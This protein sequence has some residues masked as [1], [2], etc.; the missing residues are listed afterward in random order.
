MSFRTRQDLN[1]N[2]KRI[3]SVNG[4]RRRVKPCSSLATAC[5]PCTVFAMRMSGYLLTVNVTPSELCNANPYSSQQTFAQIKVLLNGLMMFSAEVFQANQISSMV[6]YPTRHQ[7]HSNH[8][9]Q[10]KP[11]TFMALREF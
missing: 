2:C 9:L 7:L 5:N 8:R 10:I 3:L 6:Q 1:C 4:I 11:S